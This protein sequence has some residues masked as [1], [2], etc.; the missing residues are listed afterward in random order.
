MTK[1]AVTQHKHLN[2]SHTFR[3]YLQNHDHDFVNKVET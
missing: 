2:G 1:I 3:L